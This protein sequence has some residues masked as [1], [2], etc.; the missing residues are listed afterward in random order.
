MQFGDRSSA[1]LLADKDHH[2]LLVI[3]MT[4]TLGMQGATTECL[5]MQQDARNAALWKR[6]LAE[7]RH[8]AAENAARANTD[9]WY[10]ASYP[11]FTA[12]TTS[13]RITRNVFLGI[14]AHAYSWVASIPKTDP[15][16][17][18]VRVQRSVKAVLKAEQLSLYTSDTVRNA[19]SKAIHSVRSAL[20]IHNTAGSVVIASKVLHFFNP[21]LA[22]MVDVNVAM[23]W[24]KLDERSP[25]WR[26]LLSASGN[27]RVKKIS[28]QPRLE[29]YL[30]YWEVA[31]QFR[32]R[33]GITYRDFD[34]LLFGYGR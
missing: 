1:G 20:G 6:L 30:S 28:L 22:P 9:A 14:V 8:A 12:K 29:Q 2:S 31:Y 21:D 17:Y 3:R 27:S 32:K 34:K 11:V 18:L 25:D 13:G 7:L 5:D 4:W 23:A 16:P 33:E 10:D 24:K 15:R 19:R 26:K